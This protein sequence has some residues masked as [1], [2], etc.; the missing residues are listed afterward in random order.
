[1]GS[2]LVKDNNGTPANAADDFTPAYSGG[3]SNSNGLLDVS[4]TWTYTALRIAVSGQYSTTGTVTA[5]GNAQSVMDSDLAHYFGIEPNADFNGDGAVD[6]ADFTIW[7]KNNGATSGASHQQGDANY[8]GAVNGTD[9]DFWRAQFGSASGEASG[10][11]TGTGAQML[12]AS[13]FGSSF[14]E[15][16]KAAP[17]M[18]TD[19]F[20]AAESQRPPGREA[21]AFDA[22]FE[23][24]GR[25]S[26][27]KQ[28]LKSRNA[29]SQELSVSAIRISPLLVA[30]MAT[31]HPK[32]EAV[33]VSSRLEGEGETAPDV[34]EVRVQNGE[35]SRL[36]PAR[37][38]N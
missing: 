34:I 15:G 26:P 37:L 19:S 5:I 23:L 2:I 4:E 8:D 38:S 28:A 11:L 21:S 1:L 18:N 31:D 14:A 17:Q 36:Y 13:H 27:W 32:R 20:A 22:A 3:D 7:R 16:E 33:S 35:N 24:F 30:V 25:S 12:P 6:A 9:Y 10:I 29:N